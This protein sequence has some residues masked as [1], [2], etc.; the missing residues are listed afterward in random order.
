M[1]T[2]DFNKLYDG[3]GKLIPEDWYDVVFVKA[4]ATESNNGKPM[5]KAMCKIENGPRKGS[6]LFTQFTVSA[7]SQGALRIFF[8]QMT[9][10]G[11]DGAFWSKNP[12]LEEVADRIA[13]KRASVQVEH[14]P[15]QGVDRE[16]IKG[17]R[18]SQ[19]TGPIDP[20]LL[21]VG[22]SGSKPSA[23]PTPTKSG[24]AASGNAS[25]P[26]TPSF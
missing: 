17:L 23:P 22:N 7:E 6:S 14:R 10:F 16:S 19:A 1:S 5:I 20:T 26:P 3:A 12:E 4:T 24:K 18:A 8:Q 25:A 11:M 9:V 21:A 2:I 13:G 15:W